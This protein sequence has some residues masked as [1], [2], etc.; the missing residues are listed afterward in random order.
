MR[1]L[2]WNNLEC[3]TRHLGADHAETLAARACL[4]TMLPENAACDSGRKW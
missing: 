2:C 3:Q 4:A 1:A